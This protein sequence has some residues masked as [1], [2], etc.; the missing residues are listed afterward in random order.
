MQQ[1]QNPRPKTR[2][3]RHIGRYLIYGLCILAVV[4]GLAG[5]RA[6]VAQLNNWK[7]LPRP[8]AFTEIYFTDRIAPATTYVPGTAHVV[9]FTVHNAT[10]ATKEYHY[11]IVQRSATGSTPTV[12]AQGNTTLASGASQGSAVPIIYTDQGA[13]TSIT[14]DLLPDG[15]YIQYWLDNKGGQAQ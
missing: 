8:D 12:L 3:Y 2:G 11:R 13:R 1:E 14:I 4:G 7:V 10:G 6:V 5:H 9:R 15:Q